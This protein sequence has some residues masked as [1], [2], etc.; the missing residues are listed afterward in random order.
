MPLERSRKQDI[1]GLIQN[2]YGVDKAG[3]IHEQTDLVLAGP[4]C[5]QWYE[6]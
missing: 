4:G 3:L 5:Q 1:L 6:E 2:F